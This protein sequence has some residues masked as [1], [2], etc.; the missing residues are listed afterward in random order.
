MEG[1]VGSSKML[2]AIARDPRN[3]QAVEQ[4]GGLKA[5]LVVLSTVKEKP[6]A[7]AA[8]CG[9]LAPMSQIPTLANQMMSSGAVAS[10][11]LKELPVLFENFWNTKS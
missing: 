3:I 8:C 11:S 4:A 10:V 2:A 7:T 6:E 5:A 1:F 9:T